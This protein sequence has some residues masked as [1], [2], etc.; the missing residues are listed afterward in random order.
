MIPVQHALQ[1]HPESP[2]LW[3]QMIDKIIQQEVNLTPTT[4][5]PCLYSGYVDGHKVL[6]LKQVDDF[7]VACADWYCRTIQRN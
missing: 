4:H 1:G 3:A 6:F 5:E 7:V 2:C